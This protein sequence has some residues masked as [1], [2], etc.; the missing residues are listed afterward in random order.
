MGTEDMHLVIEKGNPTL[1]P[2]NSPLLGDAGPSADISLTLPL[3]FYLWGQDS[4]YVTKTEEMGSTSLAILCSSERR[5]RCKFT[6]NRGWEE[7]S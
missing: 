1:C 2:L 6:E 4:H 5:V 3:G 7:L